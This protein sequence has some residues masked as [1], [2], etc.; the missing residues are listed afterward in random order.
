M[1]LLQPFT[2]RVRAL[3][4]VLMRS[5]Q[6]ERDMQDE[7]RFHVEMEAERLVRDEGAD[8]HEAQRL[9]NLRFGGI[10]SYKEAARDARG[11]RW[12]DAFTGDFR[13]GV[14]MLGKY[15]GLTFVGGLAMA[16]AIGIG[17]TAFELFG[18]MLSPALPFDEGDRIVSIRYDAPRTDGLYPMFDLFEA[19]HQ[20][21]S[22]K[23]LAAFRNVQHNLGA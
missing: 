9:A 8:P 16:V 10:E 4:R 18:E 20:L 15:K 22:I 12:L 11:R 19:Q 6:L 23:D 2:G 1:A 14:R 13:H 21:A 3:W 5:R 17:A 7:M